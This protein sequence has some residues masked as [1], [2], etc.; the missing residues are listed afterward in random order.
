MVN[1]RASGDQDCGCTI[2]ASGV[3]NGTSLVLMYRTYYA[4]VNG[5]YKLKT[6][7]DEALDKWHRI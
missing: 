7:T 5:R 3:V 2:L 4:A 6:T 1:L